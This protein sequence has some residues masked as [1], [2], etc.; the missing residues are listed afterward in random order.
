MKEQRRHQR[1][2]FGVTQ[3]FVR[4]GQSGITGMGRLMNLSLGGLMVRTEMPLKIGQVFGCE[5]TVLGSALVDMSAVV[6]SRVGDD[7]Y[8]ARFQAGPLSEVLIEDIISRALASGDGSIL[9]INEIQGKRVMRVVGGLNDSLRNDFIHGLEN[10]KVDEIDL[11]DVTSVDSNGLE[12]CRLAKKNYHVA[13]T[14]PSAYAKEKM[15]GPPE[16]NRTTSS[17][18]RKPVKKDR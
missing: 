6:V 4:L 8:S 5:F 2:R 10:V 17:Q 15:E 12:L 1:V 9:S 3:P 18:A 13:I 14:R 16:K 7:L 11:S